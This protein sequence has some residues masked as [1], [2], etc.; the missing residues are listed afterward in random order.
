MDHTWKKRL[1]SELGGLLIAVFLALFVRT[2]IYQPFSIP[3]GSMYP[4]L[5]VGDFLF[6]R[7]FSY[8]YSRYSFLFMPPL[9]SGRILSSM[10]ERGEIIVFTFPHDTSLDYVKRCIGRPGDRV[11]LEEGKVYING[12]PAR[13][14]RVKDYPF[15]ENGVLQLIPQ[16]KEWL[17]DGKGGYQQEGHLILKK[18]PFCK[19]KND[20]MKEK[21]VPAG[22]YFVMGDNRDNSKDGRSDEVGFIPEVFLIGKVDFLFFSTDASWRTP[23]AW[24]TG[25]RFGRIFKVVR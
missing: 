25:I 14:E 12:Y 21:I 22:H 6:V 7:K 18:D 11:R 3:S 9:F 4:N 24:I 20:Q 23:S 13:Y 17:P 1:K 2:F 19:G 10:P 5:M 15:F 16:Y 8:G